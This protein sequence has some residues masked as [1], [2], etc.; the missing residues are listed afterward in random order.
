[1][2]HLAYT[3]TADMIPIENM[4]YRKLIY[5]SIPA[6]EQLYI[7]ELVQDKSYHWEEINDIIFKVY[8]SPYQWQVFKLEWLAEEQIPIWIDEYYMNEGDCPIYVGIIK[9]NAVGKDL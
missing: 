3:R 2:E 7:P 1:M 8:M 9:P 5:N 6:I 4:D